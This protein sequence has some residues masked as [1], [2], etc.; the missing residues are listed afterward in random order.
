MSRTSKWACLYDFDRPERLVC[1]T[2]KD[3]WI[4]LIDSD[5]YQTILRGLAARGMLAEKAKALMLP[6]PA[7]T[8][9]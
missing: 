2:C 8:R 6:P 3:H 4:L 5:R 1:V 9:S 7:E